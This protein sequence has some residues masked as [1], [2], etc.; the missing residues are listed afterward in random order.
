MASTHPL[1]P[2]EFSDEEWSIRRDLAA[3][4]RLFVKYGW[5]DSIY[6]HI[7]ARMPDNPNHYL[8][9]P[10]GLM[11]DEIRASNLIVA[12]M[13][14]NLIRGDFP[15]NP[16]GHAI[17]S[18]VLMARPNVNV[19]LHSHTRA[20]MAVSCMK[21]G[22]LPLTQQAMLLDGHVSYHTYD[23]QT[24]GADECQRLAADLGPVNNAIILHNHGLLTCAAS[25][26]EAFVTLYTL[27]NACKVQVDVMTSSAELVL[28]DASAV[29]KLAAIG[30]PGEFNDDGAWEAMLRMLERNDADYRS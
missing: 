30:K 11:F 12:D 7:S 2:A 10:Y 1:R 17:H 5:T 3:C 15:F 18:A 13:D 26:R 24:S 23:L 28:P 14:G 8:I 29:A 21:C 6:T 22:L 16:A 9:N 25:M 4:Y 20:G 19:V 27:E